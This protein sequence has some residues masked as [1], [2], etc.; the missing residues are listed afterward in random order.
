MAL[1]KT[2]TSTSSPASIVVPER[3]SPVSV[4]WYCDPGTTSLAEIEDRNESK[5]KTNNANSLNMTIT[6]QS[7]QQN[8][9]WCGRFS[10]NMLPAT[11]LTE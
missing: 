10:Q 11:V 8:L 6:H 3:V 2:S 1:D 4:V 7:M 9:A 5:R